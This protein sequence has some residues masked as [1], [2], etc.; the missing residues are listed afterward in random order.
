MKA[1]P[2][3]QVQSSGGYSKEYTLNAVYDG[4]NS[5]G[6][7]NSAGEFNTYRMGDTPPGE[8]KITGLDASGNLKAGDKL[9][10]SL[11]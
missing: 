9:I 10:R 3:A 2:K 5:F 4:G 11:Y 1:K 6:L 8:G 7:V